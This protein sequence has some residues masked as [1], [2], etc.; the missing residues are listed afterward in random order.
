MIELLALPEWN[1]PL[2]TLE[3]WLA[4]LSTAGHSPSVERV[5]GE[6][7]WL[8]L[9]PL[10]VRGYAML[11]GTHVAAIHFELMGPSTEPAASLV[12]AAARALAWDVTADNDDDD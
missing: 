10:R 6:A 1:A 8:E 5:S 12:Y 7:V 4:Q 9:A 2:R 3:D 11:E